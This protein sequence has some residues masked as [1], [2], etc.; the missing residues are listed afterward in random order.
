MPRPKLSETEIATMQE[1]I[2]EAAA[3]LLHEEGFEALTTRA[4]AER[5]GV[6]HM[7]LYNYFENREALLAALRERQRDRLALRRE[8]ALRE[9]REGDL[10]VV[11]RRMLGH[12]RRM[13]DHHPRMYRLIWVQPIVAGEDAP[14][15]SEGLQEDVQ[16]LAEL[17]RLGV[18]RGC[19]RSDDPEQDALFCIVMVNAPLI[20]YSSGRLEDVALRDRLAERA[21]EAALGYL[22]RR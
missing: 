18:T 16:H 7:V 17:I 15:H 4:I 11:L 2:L 5:V 6:S 13:A 8:M 12:F 19:F 3:R 9:A 1:T 14:P 20:L 10:L 22:Q 21:V